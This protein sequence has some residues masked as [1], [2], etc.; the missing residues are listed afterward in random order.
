MYTELAHHTGCVL[1]NTMSHRLHSGDR[2]NV[3]AMPCESDSR[4]AGLV[5][6]V[7]SRI[8]KV[9]DTSLFPGTC[10]TFY[11]DHLWIKLQQSSKELRLCSDHVLHDECVCIVLVLMFEECWPL[12]NI[13]CSL[14][15]V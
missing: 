11:V 6:A 13:M 4:V 7:G 8:S 9:L 3:T 14:T 2:E 12:R 10:T 1:G 5:N 15:I